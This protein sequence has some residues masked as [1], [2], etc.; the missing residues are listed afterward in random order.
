MGI[1][2]NERGKYFTDVIPKRPVKAIIQT[3]SHLVR[4]VVYVHPEKRL[5]DELE[6]TEK[7]LAVTNA[8]VFDNK[9][10]VLYQS[11]FLA[12]NITHVVWLI[13]DEKEDGEEQGTSGT[14]DE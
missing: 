5:K 9:G 2:Y 12:I 3:V 13:P 4:G 8:Q 1:R 6:K 14:S 7:F 11:N 10:K